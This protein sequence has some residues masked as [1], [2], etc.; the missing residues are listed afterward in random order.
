MV[1]SASSEFLTLAQLV[2]KFSKRCILGCDP[3]YPEYDVGTFLRM[4]NTFLPDCTTS[5][6]YSST[7][8]FQILQE[9]I[10]R[11]INLKF[12]IRERCLLFSSCS[13]VCP[14]ASARRPLDGFPL[15]IILGTS[16]KICSENPN[17]VKIRQ[18]YRALYMN[19]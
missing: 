18:K 11:L 12:F 15:N 16:V 14:R 9:I 2:N 6:A 17:L 19:I 5:C 10:C 3:V 8:E 7:R 13:S 4:S 1:P